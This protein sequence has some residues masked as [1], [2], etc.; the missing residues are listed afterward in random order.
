VRNQDTGKVSNFA[1]IPMAYPGPRPS[2]PLTI[3]PASE[4][5]DPHPLNSLS[6]QKRDQYGGGDLGTQREA[7]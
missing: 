5:D 2:I 3:L 1:Y 4:T 6:G 7:A